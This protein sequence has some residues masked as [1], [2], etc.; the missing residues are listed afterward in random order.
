MESSSVSQVNLI[1]E[2]TGKKKKISCHLKKHLAPRTVRMILEHLPL[3]GNVHS[4]GN[5][6]KYLETSIDSGIER[7]RNEFKKGDIAFLPINGSICFF[8]ADFEP[9]KT[10]S[11]IG[12]IIKGTEI[13][14]DVKPG[15]ILS[16]YA[17]EAPEPSTV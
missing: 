1:L 3:K 5:N 9:G 14:N 15:D 6:I 11:I 16:L 10:M 2:V 4:I 13:L 17:A 7:G 8:L 12:K